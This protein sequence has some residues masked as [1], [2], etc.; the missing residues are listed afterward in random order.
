MAKNGGTHGAMA[1]GSIGEGY[2]NESLGLPQDGKIRGMQS[3]QSQA[4]DNPG[5]DA[6]GGWI[7]KKGTPYGEAAMFNQLPPGMD[8]SAQQY[9]DIR[10]MPLKKVTSIS[11]P[12]DGA[13]P[14]TDVK[15]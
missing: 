8:I 2:S 5:F 4:L 12:G 11:Y 1:K 7:T 6:S 9:S 15:E 13:F 14:S 10:D 3:E